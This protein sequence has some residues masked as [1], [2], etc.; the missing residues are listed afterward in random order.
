MCR[1]A[2]EAMER[3][4]TADLDVT[5]FGRTLRLVGDQR[6]SDRLLDASPDIRR[7]AAGTLKV[8]ALRFLAPHALTIMHGEEWKRLRTFNELVLRPGETHP[9]ADAFLA[10]VRAA[11]AQPVRSIDDVRRA[12]GRAMVDITLGGRAPGDDPAEDAQALFDVIQRPL[13]RRLFGWYHAARRRRLYEML[14][15]RWNATAPDERT[16]LALAKRHADDIEKHVRVEQLPHWMFTFTGSGSD[17]LT[18][19]LALISSRPSVRARVEQEAR[20]AGSFDAVTSLE[21]LPYLDACLL[22]AGRLFPPVGRTFHREAL[23]NGAREYV[24]YFPLLHRDDALGPT[25]HAFHPERWLDGSTDAAERVT[26]VFL[27]GPRLCPGRDLIMFV[28]RTAAVRILVEQSLGCGHPRLAS[29][30]LPLA[31][32]VTSLAFS[33]VPQ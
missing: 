27:R 30:P 10:H 17:L 16:L 26:N 15:R 33:P 12:M 29:D 5:V 6:T 32:P 28:C 9:F 8:D 18:R 23:A 22:E 31:F 20:A 11:F 4:E 3:L 7:I 1:W 24:H 2:R 13:Q 19:A 21:R 25:V 14:E